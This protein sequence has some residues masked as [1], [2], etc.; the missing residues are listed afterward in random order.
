MRSSVSWAHDWMWAFT[1]TECHFTHETEGLWPLHPKVSH[2]WKRPRRPNKLPWM[3]SRHAF[4]Y[5]KL[6]IM[7]H[8]SPK[9]VSG[10]LL[11]VGLD[12]NFS[13]SQESQGP[14]TYDTAFGRE[15][16]ALTITWPRPLARVC[17][18]SYIKAWGPWNT[19]H[20]IG[21]EARDDPKPVYNLKAW[22]P[23]KFKRMRNL[24]G[25]KWMVCL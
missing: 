8:G 7:F 4:L 15:S 3:K 25:T 14:W 9:F 16:M 1:C 6:W 23:N 18:G 19:N 11:G 22:G 20:V 10:P 21:W 17:S 2:L 12:A 5:C 13:R 24:H